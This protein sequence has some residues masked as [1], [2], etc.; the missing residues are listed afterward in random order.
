MTERNRENEVKLARLEIA[1]TKLRKKL[2]GIEDG[3]AQVGST[4]TTK[5]DKDTDNAWEDFMDLLAILSHQSPLS[6]ERFLADKVMQLEEQLKAEARSREL[7]SAASFQDSVRLLEE[8]EA[9]QERIRDLTTKPAAKGNTRM[10]MVKKRG[11]ISLTATN[12]NPFQ[13]DN[14]KE[15]LSSG[16][17]FVQF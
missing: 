16:S 2:K 14:L 6:T 5:E 13:T 12:G 17:R 1:A 7:S 10:G 8:N 3:H 11:G 15:F 4:K 9:L